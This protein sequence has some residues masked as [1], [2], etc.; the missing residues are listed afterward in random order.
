[1][2]WDT[3]LALRNDVPERRCFLIGTTGSSA[4]MPNNPIR[5]ANGGAD[6]RNLQRL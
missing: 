2:I 4:K 3:A 6:E 1:M 5:A